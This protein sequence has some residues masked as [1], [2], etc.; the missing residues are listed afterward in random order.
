[1]KG[2]KFVATDKIKNEAKFKFQGQSARSQD[3]FDIE[4]DCI[5]VNFSR[6]DPSLYKKAFQIHEDRQYIITIKCFQVPIGNV[7]CVESFKFQNGAPILKYCQKSLKSCCFSNLVSEFTSI[8]HN[9]AENDILLLIDKSL[10]S[11]VGKRI[12]I[13]K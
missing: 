5:E 4:F 13:A 6:R 10:E 7:K 11:E 1:M 3:C 8:N 12:D 2:L 9:K